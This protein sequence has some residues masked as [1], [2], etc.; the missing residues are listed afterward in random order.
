MYGRPFGSGSTLGQYLPLI[1]IVAA[2]LFLPNLIKSLFGGVGDVAQDVTG[3][4]FGGGVG[5]VIESAGSGIGGI[6]S[7]IFNGVANVIDAVVP[8]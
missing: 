3:G 8:W 1:L 4:S 7:S 6:F 5:G 2:I